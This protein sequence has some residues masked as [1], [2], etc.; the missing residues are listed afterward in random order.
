LLPFRYLRWPAILLNAAMIFAT[1]IN[2]GHYLIDL[3]GGAVVAVVA[4]LC[5]KKMLG[6]IRLDG[7][8]FPVV[9]NDTLS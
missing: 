4:I 5:S 8:P 1:L 3:V 2:G 9:V 7:Q 6:Q